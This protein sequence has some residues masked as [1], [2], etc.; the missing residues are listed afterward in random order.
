M[1]HRQGSHA[2]HHPCRCLDVV[3]PRI[4]VW[5]TQSNRW[6]DRSPD[7]VGHFQIRKSGTDVDVDMNKV[8]NDSRVT[9]DYLSSIPSLQGKNKPSPN[10]RRRRWASQSKTVC[11]PPTIKAQEKCNPI[12]HLVDAK[13]KKIP[14]SSITSSREQRHPAIQV[15]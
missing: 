2:L 12:H 13:M 10:W 6:R 14:K 7:L 4:R 3:M 1:D 9:S 15:H 5:K 8:L 11:P